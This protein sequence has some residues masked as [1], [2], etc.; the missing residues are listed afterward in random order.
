MT[1]QQLQFQLST[2]DG[3]PQEL[4]ARDSYRQAKRQRSQ[5]LD[6]RPLVLTN[7]R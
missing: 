6:E 1:D 4:L 7:V 5:G 3:P 2:G